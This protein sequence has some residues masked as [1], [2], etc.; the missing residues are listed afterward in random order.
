MSPYFLYFG[1]ALSVFESFK[2]KPTTV[3]AINRVASDT[4]GVRQ[5]TIFA[6]NDARLQQNIEASNHC[7]PAIKLQIGIVRVLV[8]SKPY[9]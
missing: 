3:S 9:C 1:H 4:A 2:S 8:N 6:M 5:E 7:C